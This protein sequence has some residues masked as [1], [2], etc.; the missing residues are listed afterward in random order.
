M[1]L[2]GQLWEQPGEPGFS[3]ALLTGSAR[4][5]GRLDLVKAVHQPKVCQLH[6]ALF[7]LSGLCNVKKKHY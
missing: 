2:K 3:P 5:I 1:W 7:H 6:S 4:R